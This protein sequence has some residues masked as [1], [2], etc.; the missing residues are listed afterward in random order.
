M[1][2]LSDTDLELLSA[3]L[4]NELSFG[5]RAELERRL[6]DEPDLR[7]ELDD[8][9]RVTALVRLS[10]LRAPRDFRLDPAVYGRQAVAAGLSRRAYM[11]RLASAAS[12]LAAGLLL[13]IGLVLLRQPFVAQPQAALLSD[14]SQAEPV[15]GIALAPTDTPRPTLMPET[16]ANETPARAA[17]TA[18]PTLLQMNAAAPPT[19]ATLLALPTMVWQKTGTPEVDMAFEAAAQSAAPGEAAGQPAPPEQPMPSFGAPDQGMGEAAEDALSPAPPAGN[20]PAPAVG[21]LATPVG[22]PEEQTMTAAL[23]SPPPSLAQGLAAASPTATPTQLLLYA[24]TASPAPD[25]AALPTASLTGAATTATALP[26]PLPTLARQDEELAP[27]EAATPSPTQAV[28]PGMLVGGAV[29][30]LALAAVFWALS[31]RAA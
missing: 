15:T 5:E 29:I 16:A 6:R 3:Y 22:S 13:V 11:Y 14:Q 8:L 30:L 21:L 23:P 18:T 12:A 31:R 1:P 24:A 17:P 7:A 25:L 2:A 20:I 28:E 9:R 10:A 4:D 27:P 19:T 26:S